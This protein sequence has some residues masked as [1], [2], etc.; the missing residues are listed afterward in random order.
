MR[1][2]VV[3]HV[4]SPY[5]AELF[6]SIAG[7]ERVDLEVIYLHGVHRVCRWTKRPLNHNAISLDEEVDHFAEARE[8]VLASD[9][10]V[11]SYYAERPANL[12]L[13][14]RA[15]SGKPWCFWGERPGTRRPEYAGRLLRR[16][17]LSRL[18][19]SRAPIWGIGKLAVRAYKSE[20]GPHRSY[21]NVP[22]FSNLDRFGPE[23][24]AHTSESSERVFLFGGS[25]IRRKGVDLLARAF[26]QIASEIPSIRLRIIGEGELRSA[27]GRTL[28]PV[29]D[30]VEFL[31]FK[32]WS[33]LPACYTAADV[34]C[35]PSRYD[36][37]G[38]VVPE[39]LASGLPVIATDRMGAA[40]ELIDPGR[41]GWLIPAGNEAA[42]VNVL[43]EA[44]LLPPP[45]LEEM[46][47]NA[48]ESVS[49]HSLQHG[50]ER[51]INAAH[52]SLANWRG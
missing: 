34:F 28:E 17:K 10:A 8:R 26:V 46:S 39:G 52:K 41:N 36:G 50:A 5:Q 14:A 37:W 42:L 27:L 44:A 35:V 23:K 13:N 48:R 32:D 3:T 4:D 2:A 16:W 38:M 9:L 47:T 30:R 43:R 29:G 51:F 1:V 33:E 6:D 15:A 7:S 24:R 49:G 11:I 31:G 18:H 40:L 45:K 12:L 25:L 22:Y 20:F 21:S 19:G